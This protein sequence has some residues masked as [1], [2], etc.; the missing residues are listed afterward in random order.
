MS[1]PAY[2]KFITATA[3]VISISA[4]DSSSK[5]PASSPDF[6]AANPDIRLSSQAIDGYIVGAEVS[7]DDTVMV[8]PTQAAGRFTC[9]DGTVLS[10]V[11]GGFDVGDNETAI[12][13]TSP[14]MG[15]LTAPATEPFVTP[16]TTLSVAIAKNSEG[17]FDGSQYATAQTSLANK[18]GI[19][20]EA[21]AGN[22]IENLEAAKSNAMIHQVL[23]AFSPGVDGYED[24]TSAFAQ[25]ISDFEEGGTIDLT[26]DVAETM[27][28]INNK[29]VNIDAQ[30]VLSF[31]EISTKSA[32]IETANTS[33]Q[34]A[35]DTNSVDEVAQEA[36]LSQASLTIDRT[37]AIVT[38]SNAET[39]SIVTFSL[40]E[41]E[42]Q[43]KIND[44]FNAR[45]YSGLT[46]IAYSKDVFQ[47]NEDI[48][49]S[50]ITVAFEVKAIDDD[51]SRS[52]SFST[53][54]AVIS[55]SKDDS[56]SLRLFMLSDSAVIAASGTSS[57]GVTTDATIST[58]NQAFITNDETFSID[59]QKIS[60]G[61]VKLGFEDIFGTSGNFSVTLAVGGLLINEKEGS[62]AVDTEFFTIETGS[63]SVTGNGF[64]GY[65]SVVR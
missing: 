11:S 15:V 24:A 5:P 27:S 17:G 32:E 39:E 55:A 62:V 26:T 47:F 46:T 7:C 49:D 64:K 48:T 43:T 33:I 13:G 41:F 25:V 37:S 22:P 35:T 56:A 10:K 52:L 3:V 57:T 44:L 31:S 61:L 2:F 16:M 8:I 45:F 14:F 6:A 30:R 42:S 63:S 29:M 19:S 9:P 12:S 38:L 50:Q 1:H 28:Q 20:T 23:T 53:N 65:V 21:L 58:D 54:D 36:L 34:S 18:L 4:C 59:L 60:D 51:D 40:G